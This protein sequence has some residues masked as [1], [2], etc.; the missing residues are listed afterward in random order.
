[1]EQFLL[2]VA[3]DALLTILKVG[4]PVLLVGL[5]VGL[6]VSI[7]QATTQIQEQS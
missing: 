3:R 2:D 6:A 5:V 4:I 1:M 7:F